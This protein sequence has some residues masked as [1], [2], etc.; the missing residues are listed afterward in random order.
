MPCVGVRPARELQ[1]SR[2]VVGVVSV[3]GFPAG[4]FLIVNEESGLCLAARPGV[5]GVAR[6][7]QINHVNGS[8]EVRT[9]TNPPR[10]VLEP[11]L[12]SGKNGF[13]GWYL[14]TAKNS[15][16]TST[17]LLVHRMH[18]DPY[19]D[20]ALHGSFRDGISLRGTGQDD[21]SV[22]KADDGYITVQGDD[23]KV[24]TVLDFGDADAD[25]ST[26]EEEPIAHLNL[27]RRE[28]QE[29]DMARTMEEGLHGEG[30]LP[31]LRRRSDSLA[32]LQQWKF[33][34]FS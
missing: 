30:L 18:F 28:T 27:N 26:Y 14:D 12:P 6:D 22:L 9:F 34:E 11:R 13:Q 16:G 17:N 1:L 23:R 7:E 24:L 25:I 29:E 8:A 2:K 21:L 15:H 5:K 33:V 10:P 32:K 3:N 31:W 20:F 19:G 4:E